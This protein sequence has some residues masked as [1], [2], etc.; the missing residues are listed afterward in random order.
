MKIFNLPQLADIAPAG[1]YTLG[2]DELGSDSV[3]MLYARLRPNGTSRTVGAEAGT[4]A[5]VLV[6]KGKVKVTRKKS[7]FTA[8][9]GEAFHIC[10]GTEFTLENPGTEEAVFVAATGRVNASAGSGGDAPAGGPAPEKTPRE[11]APAPKDDE[12]EDEG[13]GFVISR[14][15]DDDDDDDGG[16]Q[17]GFGSY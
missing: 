14:G 1:D 13:E 16:G 17:R 12:G 5:L 10:E 6:L 9:S 3:S 4:E 11:T 15:G 8:A 7:S 2:P